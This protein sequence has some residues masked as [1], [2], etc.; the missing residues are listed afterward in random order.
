MKILLLIVGLV[1]GGAI[2]WYTAP[3]PAVDMKIGG[4][5][6]EV[7]K[8]QGGAELT[9]TGPKGGS[10]EIGSGNR[11]LLADRTTRTAIFAVGGGIVGLILGFLVGGRRRAV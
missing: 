5:T 3:A 11:S 9:A 4:V 2:G 6:V 8:D 7:Q 10:V 1:I